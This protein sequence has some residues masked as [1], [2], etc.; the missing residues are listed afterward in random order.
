MEPTIP[1]L[2]W[3][4]GF[5]D[6]DNDGLLDLFVAN[7][8]LFPVIDKQNWGT[9]WAERPQLFR[10]LDGVRFQELPPAAGSGLADVI[11]ARGA[12]FG[13]LFNDGHIDVVINNLDSTPTLLRN[14]VKNGN[15]WVTLKLIGGHRKARATPSARKL[16]HCRRRA[17]ARGFVQRRKLRVKLRPARGFRLGSGDKTQGRD[18]VAERKESGSHASRS[19]S[20]LHRG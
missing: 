9:T 20:D 12:A 2:K 3:G 14:V 5:L 7:G 4:T 19:G 16:R 1:F 13:D 15:H 18:T 10:N 6:F 17:A 8:H 11:P